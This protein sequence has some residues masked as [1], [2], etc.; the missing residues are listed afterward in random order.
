M[1]SKKVENM[2]LITGDCC[3]NIHL[4]YCDDSKKF[5]VF[6][7]D[8]CV[9]QNKSETKAWNRYLKSRRYDDFTI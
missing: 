4:F 2:N 3:L 9:Y 7:E 6:F 1:T 5:Y 8:K